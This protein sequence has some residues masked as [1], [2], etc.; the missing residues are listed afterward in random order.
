MVESVCQVERLEEVCSK[1]F[2][3]IPVVNMAGRIIGLIPVNFIIVLLEN[4]I[5]Y[6]EQQAI[7]A[8]SEH[9]KVSLFYKTAI[10]RQESMY[11]DKLSNNDIGEKSPR[12]SIDGERMRFGDV[13]ASDEKPHS[14]KQ[15]KKSQFK[16][17]EENHNS[18]E[19]MNN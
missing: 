10:T 6:D 1:G 19:V 5:F 2:N 3:T 12:G 15:F 9:G 17:A 14:K 8:G 11:G 18:G 13:P 7:R 16:V 4:H